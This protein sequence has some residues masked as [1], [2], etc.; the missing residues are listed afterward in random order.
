MSHA[1][2]LQI[3]LVKYTTHCVNMKMYAISP[4]RNTWVKENIFLGVH[5]RCITLLFIKSTAVNGVYHQNPF[6][7]EHININFMALDVNRRQIP[8][9]A[10]T[11]TIFG[12]DLDYV[13]TYMQMYS[14]TEN[15][16]K[17]D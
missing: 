14:G 11:P 3:T 15:F 6:H 2:A 16:F 1:K 17:D 4:N 7:F 12:D 5:P 9:K 10:F 8:S 13:C